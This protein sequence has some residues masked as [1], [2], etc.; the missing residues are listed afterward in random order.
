MITELSC[1]GKAAERSAHMLCYLLLYVVLLA[2]VA[3]EQQL[4]CQ[5]NCSSAWDSVMGIQPESSD[6]YSDYELSVVPAHCCT[7]S[8]ERVLSPFAVAGLSLSWFSFNIRAVGK[9]PMACQ[10]IADKSVEHMSF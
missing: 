7:L 8:D 4:G 10:N 1:S 2:V 9:S 3:L 5:R 6:V